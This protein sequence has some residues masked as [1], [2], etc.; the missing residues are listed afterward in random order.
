[1]AKLAR[2][3]RHLNH[4]AQ[5]WRS[6]K[7]NW[8]KRGIVIS[9][10]GERR[11]TIYT[12]E[13]YGENCCVVVPND[14]RLISKIWEFA[15]SGRFAEELKRIDPG[16]AVSVKTMLAVHFDPGEW[17][18]DTDG[19]PDPTSPESNDP[20]QWLFHGHPLDA[21]CG[22]ALLVA[23]ARLTGYQW[24]VELDESIRLSRRARGLVS[25]CQPLERLADEDGIVCIP[26]VRGERP[27]AERVRALLAA[28]FRAEW[29]PVKEADLLAEVGYGGK[30]LEQWIRDGVFEQ[31]CQLFQQRPFVWQVWDGRRDGFSALVNYHRLDRANL[32]KLT[33]T[34][35]GEWIR[36]QRE[37]GASGTP[38]A[39]L[40]LAAAQ[41]LQRKL[42]LIHEGE[43]PYDI[44]VRWKPL[45]EQPFGWEPDLNDGVRLNIRPFVT[46]GVLRKNPKIKWGK[47]RGK[48]LE[49]AP[50]YPVF[51][52]DRIND[53]HLALAE[54]REARDAAERRAAAS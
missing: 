42:R 25:Q 7:P 26:S 39:D 54:K 48:D 32:E 44:F 12:G 41:E 28:A 34:Y 20:M 53:H 6:G 40:R 5:Q 46:A 24:P 38:G 18:A 27:A 33:Y 49:S 3:V 21:D 23:V 37:A 30:S 50:W 51:K 31:H 14:E 11:A 15:T 9:L 8:G 2:S 47:D 43:S 19:T 52:G 16:F 17:T 13:I 22:T 35:L 1:M 4:K 29:S 36:Q 45:E 10:V